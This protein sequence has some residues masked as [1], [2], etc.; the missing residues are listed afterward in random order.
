MNFNL[1]EGLSRIIE[2]CFWLA[3]AFSVII[4]V[5]V[6]NDGG[7]RMIWVPIVIIGAAYIIKIIIYY[8]LD[9]FA[10]KN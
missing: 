4:F 8:I 6:F 3:V 5:I 7:I 10:N 9:G 1:Y 2:I